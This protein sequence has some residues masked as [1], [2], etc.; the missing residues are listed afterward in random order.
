MNVEDRL[1]AALHGTADLVED[2]PRPLPAVR[3]GRGITRFLPAWAALVVA[4][5]V[6]GPFVLPDGEPDAPIPASSPSYAIGSAPEFYVAVYGAEEGRPSRF[7]ARSTATGEVRDVN[8][9]GNRESFV[10]IASIPDDERKG[11]SSFHLLTRLGPGFQPGCAKYTVYNI[12]F[13]AEGR[14]TQWGTGSISFVALD[15]TPANL[16]TTPKGDEIAY[17]Y[18][19]C[20]RKV[21]EGNTEHYVGDGATGERKIAHHWAGTTTIWGAEGKVLN[22]AYSPDGHSLAVF[23]QRDIEGGEEPR[24]EL[25]LMRTADPSDTTSLLEEAG[26]APFQTDGAGPLLSNAMI[27]PDG[28][29]VL[30]LSSEPHEAGTGYEIKESPLSKGE[31]RSWGLLTAISVESYGNPRTLLKQHPS[32]PEVLFQIGIKTLMHGSQGTRTITIEEEPPD[33]LAW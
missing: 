17:S 5:V 19:S 28:K 21:V 26:N 7:E 1:R 27:T 12:G 29:K 4:L 10:S 31:A 16:A 33:D 25:L 20:G 32:G 24:N 14:F 6:L 18:E 22:L 11:V 13:S 30:T 3:R 8:Y 9:A 23:R 15:G 2:R